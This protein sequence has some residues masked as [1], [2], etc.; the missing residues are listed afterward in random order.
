MIFL[1]FDWCCLCFAF[2]QDARK[3]CSDS[4]LKQVLARGVEAQHQ[5]QP[6]PH[7]YTLQNYTCTQTLYN[8]THTPY[9][10]THY[11]GTHNTHTHTLHNRPPHTHTHTHTQDAETSLLANEA[12]QEKDLLHPVDKNR[13]GRQNWRQHVPLLAKPDAMLDRAQS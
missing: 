13:L 3:A 2:L 8:Y 4:T 11:I 5:E 10:G 12:R 7:T 6:P 1:W 9:T